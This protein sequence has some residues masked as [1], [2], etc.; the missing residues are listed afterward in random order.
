MRAIAYHRAFSLLRPSHVCCSTTS[1]VASPPLPSSCPFLLHRRSF[2]KFK[3]QRKFLEPILPS[4]LIDPQWLHDN[5]H[6]VKV[7]DGSWHMPAE[8]RDT[9]KSAAAAAAAAAA[10]AV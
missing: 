1:R 5:L 3:Y 10:G 2:A 8:K 6:R 4:S 9:K 7:L